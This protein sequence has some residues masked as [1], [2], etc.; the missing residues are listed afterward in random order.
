MII[1]YHANSDTLRCNVECTFMRT[2]VV[3]VL[4]N[5]NFSV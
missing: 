1:N 3:F 5:S 2:K 4:N